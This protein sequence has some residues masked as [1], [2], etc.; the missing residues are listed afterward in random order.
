VSIALDPPRWRAAAELFDEALELS[1]TERPAFLDRV[2]A[3]G[4]ELR[5]AVEALIAADRN[6]ADFLERPAVEHAEAMAVSRVGER[7][8]AFRLVREIGRGG[9]GEVYRAER[10]D[11]QFDQRVAIKLIQARP[12]SERLLRD[13]LR[14]RRILARL[15]HPHIARLFD[16]GMT[17]DGHPYLIMEYVEGEAITTWC[18]AKRL[19]LED[20]L[21]LFLAVCEAVEA[22]HQAQVVHRDLKPSNILVGGQGHVKL[23]DFG[24]AR[25]MDHESTASSTALPRLTPLYAAPEQ[26][27]GE[28]ATAATDVYTLGLLLHEILTGVPAH[29]VQRAAPGELVRAILE[30]EPEPPSTVAARQRELGTPAV[31]PRRLRGDLDRIVLKA[32]QK[33]PAH[34]YPSVAALAGDLR[35]HLDGLPVTARADRAAKP[36]R[37]WRLEAS[38]RGRRTVPARSRL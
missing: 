9:M 13:F 16:G 29:R 31:P 28:R 24:I 12:A 11:G 3:A 6:A 8:G 2:C 23:L 34:R 10:D 15:E 38:S 18:E 37:R 5:A 22:A 26:I 32:L 35:R 36:L 14:E 33:E 21:R 1:A 17:A 7:I 27:R 25:T 4:S 30:D 20:R 19:P